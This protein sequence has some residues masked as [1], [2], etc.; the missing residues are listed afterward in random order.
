MIQMTIV[1]NLLPV[2]NKDS[3]SRIDHGF[4]LAIIFDA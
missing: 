4:I 3:I 2:K 1:L